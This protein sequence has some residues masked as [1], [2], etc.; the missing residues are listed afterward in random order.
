MITIQ[1]LNGTYRLQ[2][3]ETDVSGAVFPLV[4][5]FDIGTRGGYVTV[6][7]S[8]VPGFPNRNIKIKLNSESD[9]MIVPNQNSSNTQETDEEIIERHR[10][11]F[12]TLENLTSAAKK[13]HIKALIVSGP[14]GVGK[15]HGVESVLSKYDI[16]ADLAGSNKFK[17]YDI[18]KGALSSLGLYCKLYNFSGLDNVI[19]F[20]DCDSVF[21]DVLSLNILKAA[22]DSK[23]SRRIC[24]NTDSRLLR[25]EGIPD[26]FN[27]KGSVIFITNIKFDHVKSKKLKDHIEA[28]E[29]RCHYIDLNIA[30]EREKMLRIKQVMKDGML[31]EF[32]LGDE[33]N[34]EI[35]EFIDDNRNRVRELS[36]RTV[37]K[38]AELAKAFPDSWKDTATITLLK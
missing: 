23:K 20:D 35:L 13:G 32:R 18:V 12:K 30:S 9:Y 21:D 24:W 36:L 10:A 3:I 33:I 15:S 26:S 4:K 2:G 27:F 14:P 34:N 8:N 29:S 31:D 19:V 37:V 7:A 28:L 16:L 6:D 25:K 22:L 5:P 11:T 17:K 38:T 1:I